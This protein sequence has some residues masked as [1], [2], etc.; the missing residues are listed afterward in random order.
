MYYWKTAFSPTPY[1]R[2]RLADAGC[3]EL[4]LR[5]FDVVRE[6]DGRVQPA[7]IVRGAPGSLGE[8]RVVPVVYITQEALNATPEQE[9]PALAAKIDK[10]LNSLFTGAKPPAEI[11][12]D[13]DWTAANR[14]R[15]FSLLRE[16]R[17]QPFF[18]DRRL[19]C[20][21]RLHQIKYQS[22]SGIPPADRG[23][24]M[25]YN[26]GSLR[27]PGAH[28]SILNPELAEEYLRH[29]GDYPLPLDVALPLFD[30][31]LLFRDGKLRGILR[32]LPP[33][34]VAASP[35]FRASG[36][37]LYTC[38]ADCSIGGYP[39]RGGD[40]VRTE[41]SEYRDVLRMARFA[42]RNIRNDS[43]SV[44]LFHCDSLTLAKHPD[45]EPEAIYSA[46]D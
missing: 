35:L 10:L 19:S 36:T 5:C 7:G 22:R 31:C 41:K 26:M 2:K 45:D 13:C 21:I 17:L 24:L 14:D 18:R 46:F 40:I 32:D 42:A 11:Q 37:N 38:L 1:E 29:L 27:K 39:L 6:A 4:Y 33:E 44:L 20:T 23:L 30:W 34:S 28:N 8:L 43:L 15:Y 9:I 12:L 3:R 25:C 16:L